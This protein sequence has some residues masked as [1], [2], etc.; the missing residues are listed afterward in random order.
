M[1]EVRF[2]HVMLHGNVGKISFDETSTYMCGIEPT[3]T[4]IIDV[5]SFSINRFVRDSDITIFVQIR[6][7]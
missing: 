4:S 2:E 3:Y 5:S 7:T 1:L 6:L